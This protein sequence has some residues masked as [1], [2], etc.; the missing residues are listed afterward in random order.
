MRPLKKNKKKEASTFMREL[1]KDSDYFTFNLYYI[2]TRH[3][4]FLNFSYMSF[5]YARVFVYVSLNKIQ[6]KLKP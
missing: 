5:F 6:R 4:S 1:K 3:F 2:I